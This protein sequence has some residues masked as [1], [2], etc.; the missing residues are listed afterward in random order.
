MQFIK[1]YRSE[2]NCSKFTVDSTK[3][4]SS[5]CGKLTLI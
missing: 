1:D 2:E 4:Q 3:V 5:V